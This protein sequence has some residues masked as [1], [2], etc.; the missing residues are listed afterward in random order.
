MQIE[1]I[2]SIYIYIY[3]YGGVFV[4]VCVCVFTYIKRLIDPRP[5][6]NIY[7]SYS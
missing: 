5:K 1:N 6:V 4:C 2:E 7:S 3:I